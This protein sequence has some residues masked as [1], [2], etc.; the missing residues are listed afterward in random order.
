[1]S[2]NVAVVTGANSG[3]GFQASLELARAGLSVVMA[4]RNAQKAEEA[5]RRLLEGVTDADVTM[6]QLDVSS[7]ASIDAFE[8]QFAEQFGELDL[9]V[10][11]AGVV[12]IP[13]AR[14]SAGHEMQL[15]TNYLGPFALV[16]KLLPR[17]RKG[18]PC[19]IVNV[20]SL[21]HRIGKL[22]FDDLNWEKSPYHSFKAYANSKLALLTFT[23]EL[24]RRLRQSGSDI[25]ALAAHPGFAA[26]E[27]SKNSPAMAPKSALGR[28]FQRKVEPLT[29]KAAEAA[30]PILL[31]ACARD[32]DGGDYYGPGGFMEIAGK[33]AKAKLNPI[34][35][36]AEHGRR[37]WALSETMT[38]VRYL[39]EDVG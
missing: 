33:P 16:G 9:L 2:K 5:R 28:W 36:D 6:L 22:S 14:N 29:P 1:V 17:F 3:L 32:V 25:V 23:L 34:A 12:G 26:T 38:G 15:A 10:N 8:R 24:N 18:R 27:I 37:L 30:H 11:N 13:L 31:A 20:G 19:R 7:P 35:R 21:A 4:C 39:T